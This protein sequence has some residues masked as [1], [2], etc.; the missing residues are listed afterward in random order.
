MES[1]TI[2]DVSITALV[3]GE[4]LFPCS[5]L[6][7]GSTAGE[8]AA[9]RWAI[10]HF[11]DTEGGLRLAVQAFL[12]RTP[13]LRIVVD[14][15]MGNDKQRSGGAGNMLATD[16]L[17]RL[18][19]CGFGREEVDVVLCT[20]LHLD[21][22]GWNTMREDGKWTPT[23]PH[24]RYLVSRTE[25]DFAKGQGEGDDPLIF[26]DSVQPIVDAGLLDLVDGS[27][28]ICDEIALVPTPGHTRGHVSVTIESRGARALIS[29]DIFHNPVQIAAPGWHS[30][31]DA[32]PGGAT[33]TRR[34][35]L[36]SLADSATLL[37][38]THFPSPTA[39]YVTT[40]GEGCAMIYNIDH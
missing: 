5:F 21:H 2:G 34:A 31:N 9:I 28:R 25:Y 17:E 24:A 30:F 20:H 39:G 37:I 27:H 12:V 4:Y 40:A 32:D 13:S 3:E 16:M 7:P 35:M 29:G 14:T 23:F 18:T 6:L 36:S 10:P 38:G 26:A 19:A 8:V 33:A 1:W 22:V 11:A 15:C